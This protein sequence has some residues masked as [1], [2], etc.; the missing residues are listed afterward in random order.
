MM[1][2]QLELAFAKDCHD[3]TFMHTRKFDWLKAEL[4]L[5]KHAI[6]IYE[7]VKL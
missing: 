1:V 3:I 7:D 2:V 6:M 4:R 5:Y